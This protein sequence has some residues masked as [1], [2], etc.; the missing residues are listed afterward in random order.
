MFA[1]VLAVLVAFALALASTVYEAVAGE[2]VAVKRDEPVTFAGVLPGVEP[3]QIV[4]ELRLVVG[5]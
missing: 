2:I 1:A 5:S 4:Q 3:P